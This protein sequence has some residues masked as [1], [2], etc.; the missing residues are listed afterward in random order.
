MPF[1]K[2]HVE[3]VY[4][5]I[6]NLIIS[7]AEAKDAEGLQVF[8]REHNI[9]SADF[10]NGTKTPV[11]VLAQNGNN[12]AVEFL[13]SG[14]FHVHPKNAAKGY[15]LGG[16]NDEAEELLEKY[17]HQENTI[18]QIRE[19]MAIG[20][21][22]RGQKNAIKKAKEITAD[23][24][25]DDETSQDNW[26]AKM[27]LKHLLSKGKLDEAQAL[28]VSDALLQSCAL[29]AGYE[30]DFPDY[31]SVVKEFTLAGY[32]AIDLITIELDKINAGIENHFFAALF[33]KVSGLLLS[34]QVVPSLL[35]APDDLDN[36]NRN[37]WQQA[38]DLIGFVIPLPDAPKEPRVAPI[39]GFEAQIA[40]LVDAL[41]Q[42]A[43]TY[44]INRLLAEPW[45]VYLDLARTLFIQGLARHNVTAISARLV[46]DASAEKLE[47]DVLEESKEKVEVLKPVY[48]HYLDLGLSTQI[49]MMAQNPE[50]LMA[51][52]IKACVEKSQYESAAKQSGLSLVT[53]GWGGSSAYFQPAT[54]SAVGDQ[55]ATSSIATLQK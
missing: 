41:V 26:L 20:F 19:G 24:F 13:L 39:P 35:T 21:I 14:E 31:S 28:V 52:C 53:T 51:M 7:F 1:E 43:N 29:P 2:L 23:D 38:L 27:Q 15:I 46:M 22:I 42:Q 4:A 8:M 44:T 32:D 6:F 10:V 30:N 16:Y 18:K 17:Q 34:G 37:C 40:A 3:P 36:R 5:E 9:F 54:D 47:C 12:E 49:V 48:P 11:M 25:G 50:V 45:P 55:S 33:G